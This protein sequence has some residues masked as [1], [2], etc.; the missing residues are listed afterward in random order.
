MRTSYNPDTKY[1]LS[2]RSVYERWQKKKQEL[3]EKRYPTYV[4]HFISPS[5]A[6]LH[7]SM[8]RELWTCK[9]PC[10]KHLCRSDW[11]IRTLVIYFLSYIIRFS[12]LKLYS[13]HFQTYCHSKPRV[14][15]SRTRY[16]WIFKFRI[17]F[18]LLYVRGSPKLQKVNYL[19]LFID[20]SLWNY[21]SFYEIW[22][23]IPL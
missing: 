2:P 1:S 21:L 18:K 20:K 7:I 19:H 10:T 22:A 3:S 23:V 17:I 12:Y 13:R 16:D 6:P 15:N 8:Y 5:V 4:S 9:K 11:S 14:V